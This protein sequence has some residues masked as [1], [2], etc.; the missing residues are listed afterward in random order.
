MSSNLRISEEDGFPLQLPF[1]GCVI[2]DG[3][4][5]IETVSQ[6][7]NNK[8]KQSNGASHEPPLIL[9]SVDDDGALVCLDVTKVNRKRRN[10]SDDDKVSHKDAENEEDDGGIETIPFFEKPD[11]RGGKG[12]G[13][14][15]SNKQGGKG[16]GGK[17]GKKEIN[18]GNV[19]FY[20]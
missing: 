6:R 11:D 15:N 9:V 10:F 7:K 2:V 5:E 14:N 18:P 12:K 19:D 4:A 20:N 8:C 16:G 3:L 17:N 13:K 1:T